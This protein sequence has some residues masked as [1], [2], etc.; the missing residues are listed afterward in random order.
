LKEIFT[1]EQRPVHVE[2]KKIF[3]VDLD[4]TD[5]AGFLVK[6][7]VAD[8]LAISDPDNLAGFGP[9]FRFPFQTI[10]AVIPLSNT[11]LGVINDNNYPFSSGRV[12]GQPDPDEFIILELERPLAGSRP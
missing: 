4:E 7:E 11:R 8:L 9:T 3:L 6:H 10:E 1:S 2:F 12:S 5:S